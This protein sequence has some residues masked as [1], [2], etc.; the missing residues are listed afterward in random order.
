MGSLAIYKPNALVIERRGLLKRVEN[1]PFHDRLICAESIKTPIRFLGDVENV[2]ESQRFFGALHMIIGLSR[3][4]STSDA[5]LLFTQVFKYYSYLTWGEIRLA[6]EYLGQGILDPFLPRNGRG[7]ADKAHYDRF[8][9]E[10]FMRIITAYNKLKSKAWGNVNQK[11][12]PLPKQIDPEREKVSSEEYRQI[13]VNQFVKYCEDETPPV[14]LTPK[15]VVEIL[16]DTGLVKDEDA[17]TDEKD[18]IKA[19]HE[20][21][22]NPSIDR[23]KKVEVFAKV[24]LGA[25]NNIVGTTAD[26]HLYHRIITAVFDRA[27]ADKTDL[28]KL[29][30]T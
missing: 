5:K 23:Q 9:L 12:L 20:V 18:L 27:K 13:I 11:A 30:C 6:F 24:A 4:L 29:L 2:K 1:L 17:K 28:K 19:K 3:P 21:S 8:S 22:T 14:F 16:T 25:L 10:Y 7:E 15:L 26:W